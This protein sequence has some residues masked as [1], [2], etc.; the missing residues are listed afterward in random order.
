MI[1]DLLYLSKYLVFTKSIC[2][3][4]TCD[5]LGKKTNVSMESKIEQLMFQM[6]PTNSQLFTMYKFS[7]LFSFDKHLFQ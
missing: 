2:M 5:I 3:Q 4:K 6:F 7:F 1:E